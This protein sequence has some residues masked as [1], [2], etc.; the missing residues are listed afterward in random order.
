MTADFARLDALRSSLSHERARL[1]A[2]RKPGDVATRKLLV[3]QIAQ[4]ERELALE[5]ASLAR[6]G[7][8]EPVDRSDLIEPRLNLCR[9]RSIK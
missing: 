4:I 1:T 2:P 7:I 6:R 9:V 5:V 8:V 3:A